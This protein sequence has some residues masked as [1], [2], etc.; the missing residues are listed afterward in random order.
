[1]ELT[2]TIKQ[3]GKILVFDSGFRKREVVITTEEQY[4]QHILVELLGDRVD[5]INSFV[6]GNDVTISINIR[7]REWVNP[8]GETKY[9]NIITGW[10]IERITPSVPK[11]EKP[12][13]LIP[14]SYN[15]EQDEEDLPF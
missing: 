15:S 11:R 5:I 10:K 13:Y 12:Q 4:P 6:V 9:F 8:Q 14:P 1:M 2:G 3:I 7:G